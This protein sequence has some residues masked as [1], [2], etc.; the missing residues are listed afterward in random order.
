MGSTNIATGGVAALSHAALTGAV[1][2]TLGAVPASLTGAV[3]TPTNAI[4]DVG[5]A[6]VQATLNDN[7][8]S[9]RDKVN[10]TK[11]AVEVDLKKLAAKVNAVAGSTSVVGFYKDDTGGTYI[12]LA[13]TAAAGAGASPLAAGAHVVRLQVVA[14]I[15]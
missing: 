14:V 7:F 4:A 15:S 6:F 3:G 1:D 11:T 9:L 12:D 10:L 13:F 2:D 8:A 5:A